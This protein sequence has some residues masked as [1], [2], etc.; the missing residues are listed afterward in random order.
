M[1]HTSLRSPMSII[2]ENALEDL[3]AGARSHFLQ[4]SRLPGIDPSVLQ[5]DTLSHLSAKSIEQRT[6]ARVLFNRIKTSKNPISDLE[7]VIVPQ[8]RKYLEVS[9]SEAWDVISYL[10]EMATRATD[11]PSDGNDSIAFG[12]QK[13]DWQAVVDALVLLQ[14]E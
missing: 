10:S 13:V 8:L 1:I 5:D 12:K 2:K 9:R 11:R 7:T 14:Y 4:L 3:V 6:R